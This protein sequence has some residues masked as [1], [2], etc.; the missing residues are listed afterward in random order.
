MLPLAFVLFAAA[1]TGSNTTAGIMVAAFTI[2]SALAPL[3]GRVVDRHGGRALALFACACSLGVVLLVV[4][5]VADAPRMV[6]VVLSALA[7]LVVPPLGPFTRAAWGRSLR[8]EPLQRVFALDSAG[9][10]AALIVAPLFVS[11]VVA[12]AS[13]RAA[14]VIAAAGM[15]AG[16]VVASRSAFGA[17]V[18]G[19]PGSPARGVQR[20][21]PAV[22]FVILALCGTGLA[23][24]ALDVAVPAAAREAGHV[25]VAGVLLAV[26]ALGTAA[27][28]LATGGRAW[29]WA[30]ARRVIVLQALMGAGLAVVALTADRLEWM[31]LALL[32]PGA[33][34]GVLFTTVYLLID[35]LSPE[36]TGTQTFAWL[37]TANNGGIGVGA[38]VA[39]ALSEASGAAAG[40]WFA[41]VCALAGAIPAMVAAAMSARGPKPPQTGESPGVS[42]DKQRINLPQGNGT[43][44]EGS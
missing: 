44:G 37:V 21:P 24:G 25:P 18:A 2:A 12:V 7:G 22:W 17:R 23:L 26:M 19:L 11:L 28:S 31:G 32:I 35:S 42:S 36:G 3:R 41:A 4:A 29:R 38:G 6:L 40:L 39:G 43:S 8:D 27:G 20:L 34:L 33:T 13:P 14:L 9:E 30:P 1:E 5:A 15:L 10:E 16:T